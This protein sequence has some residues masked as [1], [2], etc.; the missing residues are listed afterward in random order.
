[1]AVEIPNS[2]V[3]TVQAQ[4]NLES[5]ANLCV[6]PSVLLSQLSQELVVDGLTITSYNITDGGGVFAFFGGPFTATLNIVNQS[7][8]EMDDTDL[9]ADLQAALSDISSQ[10]SSC[11]ITGLF[12]VTQVTGPPSG[13]NSGTTTT[14]ATG[15]AAAAAAAAAGQKPA[16]HQC[17]DPSWAWYEDIPQYISCLTNKGLTTVG[18]LA[19]GVLVGVVLLVAAPRVARP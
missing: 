4:I 6:D 17:G 8:Q 14:T 10:W 7:G 11:N 3:A 15:V 13:T 1:M 12:G 5:G 16:V 2:A 9:V 19:I 18:L